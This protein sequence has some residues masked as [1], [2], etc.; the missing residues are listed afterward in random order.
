MYV[1]KNQRDWDDFIPL[2][3]FAH[4]TSI[5]EAIGDSPF[6]CLYGH[7]PRL[8]LMLNFYHQLQMTSL[9]QFS[10]IERAFWK[11]KNWLKISLARENIQRSQQDMKDRNASQP[12]F[13][14]RQ[15]VWVYKPN[16]IRVYQWNNCVIGLVV[17]ELSNN[18]LRFLQK[19]TRMLLSLFILIEWNLMSILP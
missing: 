8:L 10:I 18:H 17:I 3:L 6:Y 15:L 19:I 14:T 16:T 5:S 11:W 13:E 9:L 12:L 2:I 4:R 1:A 7:E